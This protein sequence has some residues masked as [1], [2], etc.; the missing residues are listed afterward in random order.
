MAPCKWPGNPPLR[1]LSLTIPFA[2][3]T[4]RVGLGQLHR[5]GVGRGVCPGYNLALGL[6]HYAS[7][8]R[9][10][11]DQHPSPPDTQAPYGDHGPEAGKGRLDGQFHLH[12]L[13]DPLPRRD[14][15]GRNAAPLEQRPDASSPRRGSG[16][17]GLRLSLGRLLRQGAF[18]SPQPILASQLRRHVCLRSR[19]GPDGMLL[20]SPLPILQGLDHC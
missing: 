19:P 10:R 5:T 2:L 3:Q 18:P 13:R 15:V 8:L 17:A 14:L 9:V 20:P 4:R 12:F 1:Q 11:P 6:H 7:L 16:W